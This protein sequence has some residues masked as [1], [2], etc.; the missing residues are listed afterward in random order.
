MVGIV[1]FDHRATRPG[2]QD[3]TLEKLTPYGNQRQHARGLCLYAF[4]VFLFRD[5]TQG[6]PKFDAGAD[7]NVNPTHK[8]TWVS[9]KCHACYWKVHGLAFGD[10]RHYSATPCNDEPFNDA[11]ADVSYALW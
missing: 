3:L 11:L 5:P 6:C 1:G 10:L 2:F 9:E 8:W 4:G 7:T